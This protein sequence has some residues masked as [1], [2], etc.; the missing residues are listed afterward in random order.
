MTE[1]HLPTIQHRVLGIVCA[2]GGSKGIPG[3]NLARVG[4]K[5][6]LVHTLLAARQS[7]RLDRVI[8]STDSEEIAACARQHGVEVPF[9]RPEELARDDTPGTLP[10]VHGVRWLAE[11]QGYQPDSV[12]LLQPTS[13][14]RTY[15]DINAA[16]ELLDN[17]DAGAVISVTCAAQHPYWQK[18]V[19]GDGTLLPFLDVS[20]TATRRQN[21]PPTYALNGA[22]YLCRTDTML[23]RES[24]Y[25]ERTVAY[26][27]PEERSLDIDTPWDLHL[28]DL[29][30]R[31]ADER[32]RHGR[33]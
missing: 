15:Q 3:K 24:F 14:L 17:T 30:L 10:V 32:S 8:L 5:P 18:R 9:L 23:A 33:G 11:H 20:A 1:T 31:D 7:V 2:R 4:G 28:A 25:A 26:V 12:M 22:I 27:M 6:L 13:P 29:I 21:L 19:T 16:I